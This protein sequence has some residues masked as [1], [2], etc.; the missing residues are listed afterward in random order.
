MCE[1]LQNFVVVSMSYIGWDLGTRYRI[2]VV[3]A[4]KECAY[5][6]KIRN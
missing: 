3:F 5:H 6:G 1:S 2:Q 4:G